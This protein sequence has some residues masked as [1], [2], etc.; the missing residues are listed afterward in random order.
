[1]NAQTQIVADGWKPAVDAPVD[2][3][4][5]TRFKRGGEIIEREMVRL[6]ESIWWDCPYRQCAYEEPF[7]FK[8]ETVG[9]F[10]WA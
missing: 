6:S 1:M 4:V 3:V 9:Y 2:T 5:T 8:Y 10:K 7:E